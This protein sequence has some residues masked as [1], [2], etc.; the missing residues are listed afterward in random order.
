MNVLV[1]DVGTSSMRGI[2]FEHQGK[3]LTEKQEFYQATYLENSWVEQ[4]PA[5]WENALYSILKQSVAEAE[6]MGEKIDA[7]SIT[8]QRSSVIPV[9]EN[10][11]PLSNA[12]MWQD[13]RT[14]YICESMENLN[15]KVFSLCGSR[16]NPVFSG[17]KMM[18]I[19][20]ERPEI[21]AKTYKFMVI[22][23]YLIYLMTGR[24]CTD[25]TYGSRSLLMNI[26][27]H[28][29]DDELLEIFHVE[30]EK[31]CELVEPGSVCGHITKAFAEITGCQ[32]GIPVITAGGDQQCGAIGQGVV[33]KGVMSVTNMGEKIDAISITSQRSS[34]IPVD[35]NI[36]PLSNA[37]MWQDKRTNYICES[38]E[39]LND[40][41]FS[42][43]GSRVNPVF[44]GSK[45]MWIRE[46][47]PE[48][49]AKTYKFMVIPDYLIYLMTG[50]ICTD[51]TYGS[52]S[53]L[54]NI[55]THEWDDELL[56][57]FHVEKEKLCEL[58]EPGSVCGHITKAFAE[59]TGC[60]EG[61]PVITA[62]GDQQCGAI[63]QGVVKK[64]VMSVTTGTGGYLI[65]ATD[66]VPEN[67][68][69]DA[70]CN[71]SSVKGQ[72]ILESSVLTCCSA[73]DW[74]RRQFYPDSSFDE[75]NREVEQTPIGSHGC[76][77]VPYFMGRSTP[78][79][80]NMAKAEFANV[81]LG[82]TKQDMLRSLLE[83]ICYEIRNGIDIMNKYVKVSDIYINGGLSNSVPFNDIQTNVYGMKIIRRGK[84]DATARGALMIAVTAMGIFEN[85][86]K[87]FECISR[88]DEVKIYLPD[89]KKILEYERYRAQMNRIY[90]RV[91]GEKQKDGRF[92]FHI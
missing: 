70:I 79:W 54:M 83:G 10:I 20:E 6:N 38:M 50:R 29:W 46:E 19:R 90:K 56:E 9:D 69:Q 55:R 73:F 28:E 21:Y 67:L 91:W 60:Q 45:M 75:I 37:I 63:G 40:K 16:V 2:L 52:R 48:I 25:Y 5:D 76:L 13:K 86:E 14:N 88:Q 23:D 74:F 49:Y 1:I 81:T 35:E 8:S 65:T 4:N 78:D 44:S 15:D 30:K 31:L 36:R 47:R 32:E 89:D 92:E 33:K 22:P 3:C 34:V 59:I 26:R 82:T 62:G 43:C 27:T 80:N 57:I 85:V 17:S 51:Y 53:L 24:I 58:V 39:N 87:A 42:L 77:C 41:V 64:G 11:R 7:I 12:I 71:F 61:I 66:Q 84:A 68:E 18:W 72:Y